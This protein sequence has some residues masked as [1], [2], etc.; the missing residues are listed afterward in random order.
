MSVMP[1]TKL[2]YPAEF[3]RG[4]RWVV[5]AGRVRDVTDS[6]GGHLRGRAGLVASTSGGVRSGA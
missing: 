4:G 1:R 2:P 3:R 5:L 6:L